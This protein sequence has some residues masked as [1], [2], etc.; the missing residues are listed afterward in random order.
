MSISRIMSRGHHAGRE[1]AADG[2]VAW[3]YVDTLYDY[4]RLLGAEPIAR[5]PRGAP[6]AG[7][8]AIV[9]A[10]PAGMVAA[11]ELLRAGVVPVVFEATGRIG[12]RNWTRYFTD[13]G[14][15]TNVIAEMGAMRMPTSNKVFWHYADLFGMQTGP[16]PDPGKVPTTLCYANATY[17]WTPGS[18]PPGPFGRL[19]ADLDG[20]VA[21]LL[22]GVWTPWRR[23]DWDG[24]RRA[25]QG[26]I[27][28][29]ANISFYQALKAGIPHWT[30]GD[31][32]AFGA[33]GIGS[34][35]F[36][37]LYEINFLELLRIL[38]NQWEVDQ[39]LL[40]S[41][42]GRLFEGLHTRTVALPDG[43]RA[44]LQGLGAVLLNAPVSGLESGPGRRPRIT[45]RDPGTG[46][47]PCGRRRP[48]SSPPPPA[49]WRSRS[50]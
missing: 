15:P 12:G 24:V 49:R 25:W 29:Y 26:Y 32:N 50:A 21:P 43:R 4:T 37:P 27:D 41:G 45:Y 42:V 9:G 44:S 31:F 16:F 13:R 48:S 18:P 39:R 28:R 46:P 34:G 47:R 19:Q 20:F 40:Q 2:F 6:P 35:G 5:F 30:T 17:P 11:Y 3:P 38:V 23:R 36:G 33:L 10:G 8:V 7:S 1:A 22:A 14:E